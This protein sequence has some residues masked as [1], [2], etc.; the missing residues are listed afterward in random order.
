MS[1]TS[2]LVDLPPGLSKDIE[3][4]LR[5]HLERERRKSETWDRTNGKVSKQLCNVIHDMHDEGMTGEEIADVLPV[6]SQN[7]IYYHLREDCSH[8]YRDSI[9]YDE[10]GWMRFH[11]SNGAPS[12][13]LAILYGCAQEGVTRHVTGRCRHG[14]K[15]EPVDGQKLRENSHTGP[16]M[17]ESVCDECGDTFEHREY[18]DQRFCGFTCKQTYAGRQGAK[19]V[20]EKRWNGKSE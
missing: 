3:E 4:R 14:H 9:N 12:R 17:T 2:D 5:S 20:N 19:V 10:C 18:K 6:G 13:T 7:T 8:D 15:V 11:A 1:S 16:A